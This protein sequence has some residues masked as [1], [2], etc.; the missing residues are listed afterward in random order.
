[1]PMVKIKKNLENR[2]LFQF[3]KLQ[4][5][6]ESVTWRMHY[7]VASNENVTSYLQPYYLNII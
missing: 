2:K 4:A 5:W 1:M 7:A 3:S 6:N